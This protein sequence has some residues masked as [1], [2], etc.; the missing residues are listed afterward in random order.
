[1]Q[2]GLGPGLSDGLT[3]FQNKMAQD[4]CPPQVFSLKKSTMQP[5]EDRLN[6]LKSSGLKLLMIYLGLNHM[7]KC[8]IIATRHFPNGRYPEI[9]FQEVE[10]ENNFLMTL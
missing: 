2:E 7:T 1:M 6:S 8:L 9:C 10:S 4:C 3:M 5:S